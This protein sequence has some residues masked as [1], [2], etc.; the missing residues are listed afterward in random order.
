MLL[1]LPRLD[2]IPYL[3]HCIALLVGVAT[4]FPIGQNRDAKRAVSSV[5][6]LRRELEDVR[7]YTASNTVAVLDALS[8]FAARYEPP[9]PVGVSADADT[10]TGPERPSSGPGELAGRFCMA[11]GWPGVVLGD[12]SYFDGDETPWG[13]LERSFPGG[14]VIDGTRYALRVAK[15]AR[16]RYVH[17]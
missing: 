8:E 16:E 15:P 17:E 1:R 5:A 14:C 12:Q 9:A 13:V 10:P 11:S 6:D 7:A 3:P 2:T 4:F